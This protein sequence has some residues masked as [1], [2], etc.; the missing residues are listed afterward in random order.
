MPGYALQLDAEFFDLYEDQEVSFTEESPLTSDAVLP[1]ILSLPAMLPPS[2]KNKRLLGNIQELAIWEYPEEIEGVKL[3]IMGNIKA[4]GKLVLSEVSEDGFE[5]TFVEFDAFKDFDNKKVSDL[6]W[7]VYPCVTDRSSAESLPPDF[8]DEIVNRNITFAGS[9]DTSRDFVAPVV[10]NPAAEGVLFFQ[11]EG[12]F[13][14][15]QKTK[16]QNLFA[17]GG[18]FNKIWQNDVVE[19]P[20]TRNFRAYAISGISLFPFLRHVLDKIFNSLGVAITYNRL[21]E[22][23]LKDLIIY[24]SRINCIHNVLTRVENGAFQDNSQTEGEARL[25]EDEFALAEYVPAVSIVDFLK[26]IKLLF[27]LAYLRGDNYAQL[28]IRCKTDIL[29]QLKE[30]DIS[31]LTANYKNWTN[32]KLKANLN[33][34]YDNLPD[35]FEQSNAYVFRGTVPD[36]SYMPVPPEYERDMYYSESDNALYIFVKLLNAWYGYGLAVPGAEK[37]VIKDI[38]Q[39]ITKFGLKLPENAAEQVHN[40]NYASEF[41]DGPFPNPNNIWFKYFVPTIEKALTTKKAVIDNTASDNGFTDE[42]YLLFYR[43]IGSLG[44]NAINNPNDKGI[45]ESGEFDYPFASADK[46][47]PAGLGPFNETLELHGPDGIY[48]RFHKSWTEKVQKSR[49]VIFEIKPDAKTIPK[50]SNHIIRFQSQQF[51]ASKVTIRA[52][53][54][55]VKSCQVESYQL[56]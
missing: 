52:T 32:D 20:I 43:G 31:G 11:H 25:Y 13:N 56:I 7:P 24:S 47:A 28:E 46:S 17:Y 33:V 42:I 10:Y 16:F 1:G 18:F 49:K 5:F 14:V 26:A 35:D 21:D 51:L 40:D 45:V 50:L 12:F 54:K 27:N 55:F 19:S 23:E 48:E 37:Y 30:V 36:P 41:Y 38:S 15:V 8:V 4:Q 9:S 2:N 53:P 3:Y 29:E 44:Y 34:A 22:G 6:D 39:T